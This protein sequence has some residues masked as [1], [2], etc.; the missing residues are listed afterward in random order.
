M[1]KYAQLNEENIVVGIS[2]LSGEVIADNVILIN[3]L[4]VEVG[5]TYNHETGEF[6]PPEP[7]SDMVA[8]LSMLEEMQ[9]EQLYQTA[10][11]EMTLF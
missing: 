2:D 8:P 5:S 3:G 10:L 1:F 11:L 4:E 9:I 7:Q 6:T